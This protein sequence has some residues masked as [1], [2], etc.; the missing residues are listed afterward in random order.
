MNI[1]LTS[2]CIVGR[3]SRN[4]CVRERTRERERGREGWGKLSGIKWHEIHYNLSHTLVNDLRV[5]LMQPTHRYEAA[6]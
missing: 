4:V 6:N 3:V 5:I 1:L 2:I